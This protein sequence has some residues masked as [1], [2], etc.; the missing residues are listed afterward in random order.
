V[1]NTSSLS[2]AC[3]QGNGGLYACQLQIEILS[4]EM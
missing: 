4:T 3:P 2:L 1:K